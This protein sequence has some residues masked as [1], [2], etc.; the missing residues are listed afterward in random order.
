MR[1]PVRLAPRL[2]GQRLAPLA[3]FWRRDWTVSTTRKG[4][5]SYRYGEHD[6]KVAVPMAVSGLTT[7][8]VSPSTVRSAERL[9]LRVVLVTTGTTDASPATPRSAERP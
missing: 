6:A 5:N 1:V 2:G 4:H 8:T 3:G 7:P 9:Q